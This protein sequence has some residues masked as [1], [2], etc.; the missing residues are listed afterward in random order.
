MRVTDA[1]P[2]A[3]ATYRKSSYST[4]T[5]VRVLVG[6]TPPP[7][8]ATLRRDVER[9]AALVRLARGAR[10]AWTANRRSQRQGSTGG[11]YPA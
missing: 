3:S 7:T 9:V 5:G 6:S 2:P 4:R 11:P 8:V 1:A 10:C